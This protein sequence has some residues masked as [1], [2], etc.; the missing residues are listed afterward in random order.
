MKYKVGDKVKIKTWEEMEKEYSPYVPTEDIGGD[1]GM[2]TFPPEFKTGPIFNRHM[3][4]KINK[5]F[6]DRILT[7]K[8]INTQHSYSM[9]E[10]D[11][12]WTD[13]M[14]EFLTKDTPIYSRF[15]LL[16]L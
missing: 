10:I 11:Y 14:I 6:P 13:E 15:E 12:F 8:R 7:I 4:E 2:N 9:K 16:D 5:I 1:V 3:E